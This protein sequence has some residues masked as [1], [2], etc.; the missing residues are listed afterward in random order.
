MCLSWL[1]TQG[2]SHSAGL[3]HTKIKYWFCCWIISHGQSMKHSLTC[4]HQLTTAVSCSR[5]NLQQYCIPSLCRV[6]SKAL[7]NRGPQL[8]LLLLLSI[9]SCGCCPSFHDPV[10]VF[11]V[12]Q[13][14]RFDCVDQATMSSEMIQDGFI[15]YQCLLSCFCFV[16][17]S[18][19]GPGSLE[20][21][22]PTASDACK[23]GGPTTSCESHTNAC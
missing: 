9:A 17:G 23:Q 20:A 6:H 10:K 11:R 15:H 22:N 19:F 1:Q 14:L 7:F 8:Q 4:C 2:Y 21:S 13:I 12:Q 3:Q 16:A 18:L 5:S